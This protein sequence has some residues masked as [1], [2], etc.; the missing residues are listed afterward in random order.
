MGGGQAGRLAV[1][2]LLS[3]WPAL[4]GVFGKEACSTSRAPHQLQHRP[5]PAS[6][7]PPQILPSSLTCSYKAEFDEA[8]KHNEVLAAN[9]SKVVDDL[10]PVR[11]LQLFSAIPEE[12]RAGWDSPIG[13]T[14]WV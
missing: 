3:T 12:V 11:V 10:H 14:A 8:G 9:L 1:L 4:R 6:R 2:L 5:K 7:L 13:R